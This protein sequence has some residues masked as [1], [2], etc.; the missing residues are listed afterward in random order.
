MRIASSHIG[1]SGKFQ[2]SILPVGLS[3]RA[4]RN[5]SGFTRRGPDRVS[6][7]ASFGRS[8][9]SS[10]AIRSLDS[11]SGKVSDLWPYINR[12]TSATTSA[13]SDHVPAR[14]NASDRVVLVLCLSPRAPHRTLK[15]RGR[16]CRQ[17]LNRWI[18]PAF[19]AD[20]QPKGHP[21]SVPPSCYRLASLDSI[22]D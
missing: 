3:F 11:E 5:G 7:C 20:S 19:L 13:A 16:L 2:I 15:A 9:R 18:L 17:S 4:I 10:S 12:A 22:N 8:S 14:L 6:S 21:L 1:L